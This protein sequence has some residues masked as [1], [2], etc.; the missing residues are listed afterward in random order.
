MSSDYKKYSPALKKSGLIWTR[1]TLKEY[2]RSPEKMV[3]GT[4]VWISVLGTLYRFGVVVGECITFLNVLWNINRCFTEQHCQVYHRIF[5]HLICPFV[6][7]PFQ[8]WFGIVSVDVQTDC[9]VTY[10]VCSISGWPQWNNPEHSLYGSL[11]ETGIYK[12]G[13]WRAFETA[14]GDKTGSGCRNR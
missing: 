14:K 4:T 6:C 7:L 10:M 11:C 13:I 3:P 8:C 1:K 2:M 5:S 9:M 12:S